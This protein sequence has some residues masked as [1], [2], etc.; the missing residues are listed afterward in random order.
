VCLGDVAD[1]RQVPELPDR[2]SAQMLEAPLVEM[3]V[4]FEVFEESIK[5][6][7]VEESFPPMALTCGN[8]Y[9]K[10]VRHLCRTATPPASGAPQAA[11]TPVAPLLHCDM[12][13]ISRCVNLP[14]GHP[15]DAKPRHGGQ[16]RSG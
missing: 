7:H 13:A 8:S 9:S 5:K 16:R 14:S 10:N 4:T 12:V 1:A 6:V 3:H 11:A 2:S 15:V